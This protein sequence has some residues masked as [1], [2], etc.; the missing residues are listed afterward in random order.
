M[1]T[2]GSFMDRKVGLEIDVAPEMRGNMK[3]PVSIDGIK[4]VIEIHKLAL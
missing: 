1:V 4:A 2:N 3:V